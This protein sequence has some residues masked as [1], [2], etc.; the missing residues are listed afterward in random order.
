LELPPAA[1]LYGKA[2]LNE[3]QPATI[4]SRPVKETIR[5]VE[6]IIDPELDRTFP[7]QWRATAEILTQD[8]KRYSTTVEYP[9]GDPENPL[10]W[11][12]MIGRFHELT[13]RIMKKDQRLKIVE[14]V[15]KLDEIKD[16][17]KWSS[18]LLRKE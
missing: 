12:E 9:K 13:G 1:L 4:L 17:R 11:E 14:A 2:G 3:F 18:Q 6:C 16:M 7:R 8:E 5:K 10:S 15:E